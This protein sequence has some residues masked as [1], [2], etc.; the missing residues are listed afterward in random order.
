MELGWL[1]IVIGS[2]FGFL[3]MF[4]T[5]KLNMGKLGILSGGNG[6]VLIFVGILFLFSGIQK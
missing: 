4:G 1:L 6:I 5:A 2:L 3:G